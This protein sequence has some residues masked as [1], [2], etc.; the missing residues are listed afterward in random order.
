MGLKRSS[1]VPQ[2]KFMLIASEIHL[3]AREITMKQSGLTVP[4]RA[5]AAFSAA[6]CDL[7]F[8]DVAFLK[9][10]FEIA[11]AVHICG[12]EGVLVVPWGQSVGLNSKL[13]SG[14]ICMPSQA[15]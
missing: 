10:D 9:F 6:A 2:A 7:A 15:A 5:R 11:I 1:P 14:I 4:H 13:P 8:H 12:A 3:L